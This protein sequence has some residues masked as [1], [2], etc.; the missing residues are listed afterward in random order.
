M[1]VKYPSAAPEQLVITNADVDRINP[2]VHVANEDSYLND[3]LILFYLRHIQEQLPMVDRKKFHFWGPKFYTKLASEGYDGVKRWSKNKDIFE[4]EYLFVP[5]ERAEHWFLVLVCH[6]GKNGSSI[7]IL[8]SAPQSG[9][10]GEVHQHLCSYLTNEWKSK[11]PS[12]PPLVI[13]TSNELKTPRQDN[14]YDCGLFLLHAVELFVADDEPARWFNKNHTTWFN[15]GHI[16]EK[17]WKFLHLLS[18]LGKSEGRG[19]VLGCSLV[20]LPSCVRPRGLVNLGNTCFLNATLQ[21]VASALVA[22]K[23][24]IPGYDEWGGVNPIVATLRLLLNGEGPPLSLRLLLDDASRRVQD[25]KERLLVEQGRLPSQEDMRVAYDMLVD[26]YLSGPCSILRKIVVFHLRGR[27]SIVCQG[28]H[29][30]SVTSFTETSLQLA[31]DPAF[32]TL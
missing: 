1:T 20:A 24:T 30:E 5:V 9:S 27:K 31:V 10:Y 23:S 26:R 28:C 22:M 21:C 2:K 12:E 29:Y 16:T 11:Y 4:C 3:N 15:Q 6:P 7:C 13:P 8:D 17:R 14:G 32:Y 19:P 25:M 18:D